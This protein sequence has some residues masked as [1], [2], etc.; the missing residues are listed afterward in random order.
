MVRVSD[1]PKVGLLS[2]AVFLVGVMS[3]SG[4]AS[5]PLA[6]DL[7]VEPAVVEAS[8]DATVDVLDDPPRYADGTTLL[9]VT[10][11]FAGDTVE[12]VWEG[13]LVHSVTSDVTTGDGF[14]SGLQDGTTNGDNSRFAV[15]F[16]E[17]GVYKYFCQAH[18]VQHG[19]VVVV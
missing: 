18:L 14:D 15:T 9:P 7:D 5:L 17:P 19:V 16:D 4:A 6:V 3:A 8:A 10:V 11:V 13:S 12:W 2:A 1:L